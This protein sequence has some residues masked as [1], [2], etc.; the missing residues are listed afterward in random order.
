LKYSYDVA[1]EHGFLRLE[2]T[3]LRVLGFIDVM[4]FG[5]KEGRE[6]VKQACTFAKE[7]GYLWDELQALHFLAL[8]E[9]ALE[10][11]EAAKAGFRDVIRLSAEYGNRQYERDAEVALAALESGEDVP[12]PS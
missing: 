6:R 8:V 1:V 2:Y 3:N 7:Q 10:N 12:M 4:R 11:A 9:H 5:S